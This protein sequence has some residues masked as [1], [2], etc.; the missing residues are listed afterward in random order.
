MRTRACLILLSMLI[1]TSPFLEAQTSPNGSPL[2][3]DLAKG[4]SLES[5]ARVTQPGSAISQDDFKPSGWYET[6]VPATVLAA[7]VKN[8]VYQHPYYGMNLRE[9]PGASYPIGQNFSNLPMP[10]GSPFKVP[11]WYRTGFHLPATFNGKQIWLHFGGINYRASIWL[12]GKQIAGPN[13]VV[14]MWRTYDFNVTAEALPGKMNS[15]AVEVSAPNPDDLGITWV[16]WNPAPPDKDMGL[17]RGVSITATGPV[18]LRDP[19]VET[20]FDLPN[21]DVA[22]LTV[23]ARLQNATDHAVRGVL[24]GSIG[25]VSIQQEVELEPHETR[26]VDFLP[27]RFSQLDFH[28]PRLWWPWEMGPQNLYH[29]KMQFEADGKISDSQ[30][31]QFGIREITS[32][33]NSHGYSEFRVNGQPILILGAGWAPDMMLRFDAKR[34]EE[35]I[36]YVKNMHLNTIRLEGKIIDNHFFDLCDRYGI[37]VMAGWCCCDHWEKWKSWKAEDYTVAAESLRDQIRRLRN[38][39]CMLTWL[40]GSDNAPPPRVERIY[41]KV[42]AETHWPNPHQSSATAQ[43]TK[44][45]GPSGLKMN[46]PYDWVPPNYWLLDTKYGGAF[47]FATEISP[48]PAV[49]PLSSLKMMMP[50]KDLWPINSVWDFHA[51]G[52]E[53]KT[54]TTFNNALKGR[55]G[56]ATGVEDYAEKS[57]LM[58]YEGERAMFEGYRRNKFVST[59]VIQW[60]LNTAWP[61]LIWHLYDYY[62]RPAGGYFGTK[63]ACEPLHVQYSYDDQSVVVVNSRIEPFQNLEVSAALYDINLKKEFSKAQT[64]S[65]AANSSTRVFDVPKLDGLSTTYFLRLTLK[66][67]AGKQVSAN[68]YWLSTKPDVLNWQKSKWYYTPTSSYAD[69]KALKELPE[70]R[71][72]VRAATHENGERDVTRVTVKNPSAHLGFF[73]HLSVN[74]GEQGDEIL[75]VLWQDNYFELMPGEERTIEAS[76]SRDELQ[77]AQPYVAVDGWNITP[78]SVAAGM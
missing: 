7:L 36:Q 16:D 62:L 1:A 60:M 70:V 42:L 55:Y 25:E 45:T 64:V 30:E 41:L 50:E 2:R 39:P 35:E 68:F 53:F 3:L 15:L 47:G 74:R 23:R 49:P 8:K 66:D 76:Y 5:S 61:G 58:T 4:W 11:W 28:H 78:G 31:A 57:Q 24:K 12:N 51:G 33:I 32:E 21:L 38:H 18:A 17:W 44:V 34:T 26:E 71:L 22:H 75:P 65:V 19:Q 13:Q 73:I 37:L 6:D 29:L 43:V 9:I 69:F 52:G 46:G 59:G 67:S 20:K 27:G 40:Y 10:V 63:K 72:D 48:G 14:G 54:M 77:G 56:Q